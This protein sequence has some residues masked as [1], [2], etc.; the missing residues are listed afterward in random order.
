[1]GKTDFDVIVIGGSANGAQAAHAAAISGASVAIIEEHPTIG[2]PEHCSGLFSYSGL[3]KLD[4]FPPKDIIFNK[5]IHGSRIIAPNGKMITVRK[6]KKH[7]IV[8]DRGA[9]DRFLISRAIDAGVLL[10]QPYRALQAN[11]QNDLVTVN[12]RSTDGDQQ[13]LTAPMII[14]AEGVRVSIAKQLGLPGPERSSV[15]NAA[16]FY[17]S[18]LEGIR[19]DLVEVYQSHRYAPDFFAW[20][21]PMSNGTAKVGLGTSKK[22]AAKELQRMIDNHPVMS[23]RCKSAN[24][25]HR[26]A[27]RIP[28]AGPVKKTYSDNVIMT[29]DAAGQTKPT[30]GG[31]VILGGIAAQLAGKIAARAVIHKTTRA[32]DLKIYERLWKHEMNLN[33]RLMHLVRNY[34]NVLTDQEVDTFFNQIDQKGIA[35][36]IETHGH[37][38]NQGKL[39]LKFMKMWKLYPFYLRTSGRLFQSLLSS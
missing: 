18:D 13:S 30:T 16:Q 3:E 6:K 5:N 34:M 33:L 28:I 37:V 20:I 35:V 17:M 4:C 38:D 24:I 26:T 15:I 12:L 9:F 19:R 1:M 23:A 14:S 25:F 32:T 39:V 7:A 10:Y 29:G 21:I 31:G 2:L 8:C 36:D 11:R 22:A 27:G